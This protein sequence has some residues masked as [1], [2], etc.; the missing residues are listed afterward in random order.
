MRTLS[1]YYGTY[2]QKIRLYSNLFF[3]SS[4]FGGLIRE[5]GLYTRGLIHESNAKLCK[6][7]N[8]LYLMISELNF[9]V[10]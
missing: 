4:D 9:S 1:L 2:S 7:S 6:M 10:F 8:S 5:G 3:N